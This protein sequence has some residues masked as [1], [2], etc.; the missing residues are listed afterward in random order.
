[1][2]I[3]GNLTQL[4]LGLSL[5]FSATVVNAHYPFLIADRSPDMG[6]RG[7]LINLTYGLGELHEDLFVSARTPDWVRGYTFD[8][9]TFDLTDQLRKNGNIFNLKYRSRRI[10]DTWIVAHVPM[11][12]STHDSTFIETTVRTIIHQGLSRGWETPL[13]LPLEIVPLNQPYGLLPGDSFRVELLHDGKPLTDTKIY[14]EKYY[15]PPLQKPYPSAA[16]LT[17]T[18]R[19]DRN[20]IANINLHSSGWWVLFTIQ[21]L[22]D[23]EKDGKSGVA[24]LQDA[25]WVYVDEP[26]KQFK[27]KD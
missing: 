2:V 9:S 18:S 3:K 14:A 22:D 12:W 26:P 7:G 16:L 25:V 23:M 8:G 10:G 19:T 6:Q 24:T 21:E 27:I 1:M 5:L 20:G 4:V 15:N 13:G 17:R 11:T